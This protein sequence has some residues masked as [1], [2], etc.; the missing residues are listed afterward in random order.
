MPRR[1]QVK[2]HPSS[3]IEAIDH[4]KRRLFSLGRAQVHELTSAKITMVP[5]K[6]ARPPYAVD[7]DVFLRLCD[8]CGKCTEACPNNIITLDGGVA[9]LEINY[10]FCQFCQQCKAVCPT[11][12]L[13][14][15]VENTGLIAT[16]SNSCENLYGYCANCEQSCPY[17]ALHWQEDAKPVIDAEKCKGCGQCA[18]SCYTSMI[19]YVLRSEK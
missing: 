2:S 14:S 16:I 18:S 9:T 12:A 1:E 17:E 7:D 13:S 5:R 3:R 4:S 11:L 19:S 8:G 10:A 15:C 6:A